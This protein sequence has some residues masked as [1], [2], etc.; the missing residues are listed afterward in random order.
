LL[1]AARLLASRRPLMHDED[2]ADFAAMHAELGLTDHAAAIHRKMED[3]HDMEPFIGPHRVTVGLGSIE[4]NGVFALKAIRPGEVIAA[5]RL[6]GRRTPEARYCNHAREPNAQMAGRANGDVELVALRD[7]AFG[8]EVTVDYRGTVRLN[9]A[10]ATGRE[11]GS[12][13]AEEVRRTLL[14]WLGRD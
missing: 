5:V 7:I 14:A 1:A 13:T 10:I 3:T 11:S 6:A 9:V 2:R 8:E 4:G 12:V